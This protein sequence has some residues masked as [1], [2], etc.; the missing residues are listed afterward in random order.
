MSSRA[1]S[2]SLTDDLLA[3]ERYLYGAVPADDLRQTMVAAVRAQL[4]E[5]VPAYLPL[6]RIGAF[7]DIPFSDKDAVRRDPASFVDRRFVGGTLYRRQTSGS[8]GAPISIFYTPAFYFRHLLLTVRKLLCVV[9][10]ARAAERTVLC[11]AVTDL[12]EGRPLLSVDPTGAVGPSV[13]LVV[14]ERR[15]DEARRVFELVEALQPAVLMAKPSV[16]EVLV[17]QVPKGWEQGHV[18]DAIFNGGTF[19]DPAVRARAQ[20]VFGAPVHDTYGLSEF[21]LVGY[22][23]S[24][25][26]GF[27]VDESSVLL[28]VIDPDGGA[29]DDG[30]EGEIVLSSLANPAMPLLRYRTADLGSVDRSPCRCGLPGARII[31]LAGRAASLLRFADG[32]AVSPARF[33]DLFHRFALREFQV[34]QRREARVDIDVE[35]EPGADVAELLAAVG[36]HVRTLL[37]GHVE[38]EVASASFDRRAKFERYRTQVKGTQ[39]PPQEADV[40]VPSS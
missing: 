34:T 25:R 35:P 6:A 12:R 26:H 3:F 38:V 30:V 4:C 31:R 1:Y 7:D 23:C 22:E 10:G 29:V 8:T 36:G 20:E 19:L 18:P 24:E 2:S 37:P 28:E 32:V 11:L 17:D 16:F 15:P 9:Q 5:N 40:A 33:D 21:G 13:Q 39:S 14:D 27:H